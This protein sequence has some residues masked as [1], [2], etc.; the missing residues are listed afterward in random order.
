MSPATH[1]QRSKVEKD[2]M[3]LKQSVDASHQSLGEPSEKQML[4]M[5]QDRKHRW[6]IV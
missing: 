4:S 1:F 6:H 3:F 2:L 5:A